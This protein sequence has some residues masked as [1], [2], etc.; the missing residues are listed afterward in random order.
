MEHSGT[1]VLHV[2]MLVLDSV[3][4]VCLKRAY[5]TSTFAAMLGESPMETPDRILVS[6]SRVY[7]NQPARSLRVH[8]A[9][10]PSFGGAQTSCECPGWSTAYTPLCRCCT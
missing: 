1:I 7:S 9:W 2:L 3:L 5:P 10:T 6:Q 4:L 8:E